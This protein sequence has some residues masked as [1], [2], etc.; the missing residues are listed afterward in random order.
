MVPRLVATA[1]DPSS[2]HLESCRRGS[3]GTATTTTNTRSHP[4]RGWLLLAVRKTKVT[5][6]MSHADAVARPAEN[7]GRKLD[8]T[9]RAAP[10]SANGPAAWSGSDTP[11]VGALSHAAAG[12]G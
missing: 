10:I 12:G 3:S 11:A 9:T 4:T 2:T 8:T 6:G 5:T 1:A 7:Q